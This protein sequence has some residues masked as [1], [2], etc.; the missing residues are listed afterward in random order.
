MTEA[1][2][3]ADL[4]RGLAVGVEPGLLQSLDAPSLSPSSLSMFTQVASS[5]PPDVTSSCIYR[6]PG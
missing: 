3:P 1:V 2:S 4:A 5:S 6:K